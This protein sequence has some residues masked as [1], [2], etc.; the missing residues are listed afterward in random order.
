M[1]RALGIRYRFGDWTFSPSAHELERSGRRTRLER[2]T[3]LALELL[4]EREGEVVPVDVF[5]ARLWNNRQLS[6]NSLSVVIGDLRRAL[7]DDARNPTLIGTVAKS[8]YRLLAPPRAIEPAPAQA[9]PA[10]VGRV[11][12]IALLALLAAV[13]AVWQL[14]PARDALPLVVVGPLRNMTGDVR[15]DQLARASGE[16]LVTDLSRQ[17]GIVVTRVPDSAEAALDLP[18]RRRINLSAK[19]VL[20]SGQPDIVLVG[21]DA[22]TS[23]VVWSGYAFGP[24]GTIPGKLGAA[25]AEFSR[26]VT[27]RPARASE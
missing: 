22:A 3:S 26:A 13:A 9:P 2:R 19:L 5:A 20:W 7:D 10:P 4:C 6:G 18:A 1:E 11:G 25:V 23:N 24:E 27:K 15:Y 17:Q 12:M 16:L 14:W 21:E 8:G